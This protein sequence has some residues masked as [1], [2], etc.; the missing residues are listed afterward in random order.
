MVMHNVTTYDTAS[1]GGARSKP[2]FKGSPEMT[3]AFLRAG[4][5]QNVSSQA[6]GAQAQAL[7][8]RQATFLYI[9]THGHHNQNYVNTS[10]GNF[11]PSDI[12]SGEWKKGL[13]IV[14]IAGCSVLDVTGSKWGGTGEENKAPGRKWIG[15]PTQPTGPLIFL[16]Y[17]HSGPSD[18]SGV[19]AQIIEEWCTYWDAGNDGFIGAW[20]VWNLQKNAGNACAIDC[21]KTRASLGI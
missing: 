10:D 18:K 16:G 4:G 21:S 8:G 13:K 9:S 12:A 17:E 19:P 6:P 20:M 3:R 15:T 14:I 11:G 5:V 1:Y 7:T 2:N